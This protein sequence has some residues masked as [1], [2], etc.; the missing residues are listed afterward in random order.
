MRRV[1]RLLFIATLLAACQARPR[2]EV[3]PETGAPAPLACTMTLTY[4]E[5]VTQLPVLPVIRLWKTLD[6]IATVVCPGQ[7]RVRLRLT[8]SGPSLGAGLPTGGPF[9]AT[10]EGFAGSLD[11]LVPLPFVRKS[12]EGEYLNVGAEVGGVGAGLSPWVNRDRTLHMTLYLPTGF[13]ASA[14]INLQ[15]L[16]LYLLDSSVDW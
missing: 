15:T 8:A 16:E 2:P 7:E 3:P 9:R 6:G 4:R 11:V 10:N 12:F 5:T 13:N 14:A 1:P